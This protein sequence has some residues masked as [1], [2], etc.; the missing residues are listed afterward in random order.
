ML[1]SLVTGPTATPCSLA[2]VREHAS[3]S[4]FTD[5]DD[6]LLRFVEAAAR[7][8][9]AWSGRVLTQETWAVSF[10][11]GFCGDL[12][13]PK[14]PVQSVSSIT[15]YDADDVEQTATVSD[16]YLT[17]TESGAFLRPKAGVSW[18]PANQTRADAITV[19]FVAG[20]ATCPENLKTAVAAMAAHLYE[21]REA[22]SKKELYEVPLGVAA[23][24]E[25]DRIG[26]VKA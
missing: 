10:A 18:P 15:Y 11:N 21:N 3:V 1:V 25:P 7:S 6:M 14:S 8:V 2:E 19:T 16:F 26:W 13:L 22:V 9:S 23:L 12:H 17:T 24:I 5:D 4:G 20:Y